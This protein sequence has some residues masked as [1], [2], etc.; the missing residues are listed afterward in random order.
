M[1]L[2]KNVLLKI[3]IIVLK[4][5]IWTIVKLK[6]KNNMTNSKDQILFTD[7]LSIFKTANGNRSINVRH[8]D[9]IANN[10]LS[11]GVLK[12]PILVNENM[13]IID[14]QHRISAAK[15]T[16]SGI[17]Y[18]IVE[19][20]DIEEVHA[21]NLHQKNW[22]QRDFMEGY[23]DMGKTQYKQ[24]KKFCEKFP[25][26]NMTAAVSIASGQTGGGSKTKFN[27]GGFKFKNYSNAV[28]FTEQ[29]KKV[30]KHYDGWSRSAFIRA[31]VHLS[32]D[33]NFS[34]R[35]FLHKLSYQSRKM[36][37]CT[38]L[39]NYKNLIKEIYNYRSRGGDLI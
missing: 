27:E 26:I 7:D 25:E 14:G 8:R 9:K 37:D 13:E 12:Q 16:D 36:V 24:M 28:H 19:G 17:F 15:K 20:Y 33:P 29:L 30:S 34:M 31:L 21:L 3:C 23:A 5:Y 32:S 18:I 10:M 39:K 11:V 1:S 22:T 4:L 38:S 2:F 35:R 6:N